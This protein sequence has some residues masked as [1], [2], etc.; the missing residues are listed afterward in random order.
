VRGLMM[1]LE[2]RL[3][4]FPSATNFTD[5]N[6]PRRQLVFAATGLMTA[7]WACYATSGV[8]GP[9]GWRV[10]VGLQGAVMLITLACL[11]FTPESPRYLAEKGH[12]E[13]AHHTLERFHGTAFADA[14]IVEIKEAIALEHAA[15]ANKGYSDCFAKFVFSSRHSF[16][17]IAD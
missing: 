7:F 2:V 14:A 13:E 3:L 11:Q 12:I 10:P 6:C 15:A 16:L 5:P 17:S 9:V 4:S 8:E 1:S